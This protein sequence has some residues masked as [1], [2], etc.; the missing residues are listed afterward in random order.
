[1]LVVRLAGAPGA[2]LALGEIFLSVR[3]LPLQHQGIRRRR[4]LPRRYLTRP[5]PLCLRLDMRRCNLVKRAANP[6][7]ERGICPREDCTVEGLH[8][9]QGRYST[10]V[11]MRPVPPTA[12]G[13]SVLGLICI[14]YSKVGKASCTEDSVAEKRWVRLR[15][16]LPVFRLTIVCLPRKH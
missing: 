4:F 13:P 5:L 6:L 9:I 2:R 7:K 14:W 12:S 3:Q 11:R 8:I 10:C 16:G 1:M 15:V